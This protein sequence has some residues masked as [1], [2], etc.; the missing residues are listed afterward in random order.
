MQCC[1]FQ[2]TALSYCTLPSAAVLT[3]KGEQRGFRESHDSQ[4]SVRG[5]NLKQWP[6]M[7][8]DAESILVCSGK[9]CSGGM[10]I[11]CNVIM[12]LCK[13]GRCWEGHF[14]LDV[15]LSVLHTKS[16]LEQRSGQLVSTLIPVWPSCVMQSSR[17]CISLL[18]LLHFYF[19]SAP[20][21]CH[22]SVT[23][24]FS[25]NDVSMLE[26]CSALSCAFFLGSPSLLFFDL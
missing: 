16:H 1:V 3:S 19:S 12:S 17:L 8:K 24:C 22:E 10:F 11:D 18:F 6:Y 15:C 21:P 9:S 20:P 25:C 14:E 7:D 13:N 2:T 4:G 23:S 5:I 26:G